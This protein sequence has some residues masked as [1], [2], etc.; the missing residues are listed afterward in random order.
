MF[1]DD[2]RP[3]RPQES[4]PRKLDDLSIEALTHYIGELEGEIERVKAEIESRRRLHGEAENVF[5]GGG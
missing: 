1:E 2:D 5:K 4:F 3:V